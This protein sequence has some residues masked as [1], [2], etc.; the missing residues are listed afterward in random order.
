MSYNSNSFINLKPHTVHIWSL[1]FAV[2][3]DA[4]NRYHSLLSEDEK[5]RASKFKFYKD[6]RCYVVT[7]GCLRLLSA[8][9]L[10]KN[11]RDIV[12][13][14]EK[15]G[16]PRYKH[17]TILNFN[18]S[19]SGD[20]AVIGFVYEHAI[21]IDIEKIKNDFDTFEIASNFFSKKEIAALR[22]IPESQKYKAFYR[23]WTRKEAFIKAKGIG[24]SFPLD[25]FSVTLDSDLNAELI[26]TQW[27]TYEK[28]KWQFTSFIPSEDYIAAF[29]VNSQIKDIQYFNWDGHSS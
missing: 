17:K 5:K 25:K 19:H 7:R 4:F 18:V 15:Y 24:L 1:N 12:F 11:A 28:L 9:Y 23:C 14:Y 8:S 29:T 21:G 13:V 22:E 2:N 20:I 3:D 16:K 26:Q 27:D 10:E 6:K